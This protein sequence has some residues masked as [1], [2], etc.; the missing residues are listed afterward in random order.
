[1]KRIIAIFLLCFLIGSMCITFVNACQGITS[2][3][4]IVINEVEPDIP[5]QINETEP[6]E[7]I[8]VIEKEIEPEET[9]TVERLVEIPYDF[10]N[11]TIIEIETLI[12]E[13][14]EKQ[15]AAHT[16]AEQARTLG[17]P[18][19]CP[20][21]QNAQTEWANAQNIIDVAQKSHE[22]MM[23]REKRLEYPE[24]TEIWL[25]LKNLGYNNYVAA[26]IL[27]NIMAEVGGQTLNIQPYLGGSGFYGM[28]QWS[29]KY[30]NIKGGS[31]K[32]QCDYL[33]DT[34]KFE[35]DTYGFVY[36]KNFD[37]NSFISLQDE[38]QAA[39]AFA[40]CYERCSSRGYYTRQNNAT[41]AYNYFVD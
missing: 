37:F 8:I 20:T 11:M 2:K 7:K 18:E 3:E 1:M 31:L 24:A 23:W 16:L 34:I 40:K 17:W 32:E 39:L 35:F 33:R 21:I 13:Q 9:Y 10:E 28:C 30:A 26:G 12:N 36:Q 22:L 25:Y 41:N 5:K 38:K 27:G 29:N 14:K 15:N 19:D 6:K 4:E